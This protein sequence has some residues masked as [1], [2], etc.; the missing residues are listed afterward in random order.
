MVR[1]KI[2]REVERKG[3]LV[4][5]S[6]LNLIDILKGEREE[7]ENEHRAEA[8]FEGLMRVHNPQI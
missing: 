8:V 2:P 4:R 7:R 1:W 6:T 5:N 3:G